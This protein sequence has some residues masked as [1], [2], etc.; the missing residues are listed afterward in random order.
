MILRDCGELRRIDRLLATS[1]QSYGLG[2][3]M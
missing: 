2:R 1:A 3:V